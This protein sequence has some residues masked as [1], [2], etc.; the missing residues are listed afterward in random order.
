MLAAFWDYGGNHSGNTSGMVMLGEYLATKQK[1]KVLMLSVDI[2]KKQPNEYLDKRKRLTQEEKKSIGLEDLKK[3]LK[4][5][6]ADSRLL[7]NSVQGIDKNL[8]VLPIGETTDLLRFQTEW[9][10]YLPE[11]FRLA[12]QNYDYIL[13]DIGENQHEFTRFVEK[14]ADWVI[15]TISQNLCKCRGLFEENHSLQKDKYICVI[16]CY[17]IHSKYS[18]HN[19][20]SDYS[21]LRNLKCLTITYCTEVKDL[22]NDG[23]LG[24]LMED[25][26][27][28][29]VS[30][31]VQSYMECLKKLVELMK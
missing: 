29:H 10:Q 21:V 23:A 9:N 3:W 5:G 16:G 7:K 19:L 25:K 20:K 30:G 15:L 24:L 2:N 31:E 22:C 18:L 1:K 14:E 8:D 28:N 26:K 13:C 17:D 12:G 4:S 11:L 27:M 6:I